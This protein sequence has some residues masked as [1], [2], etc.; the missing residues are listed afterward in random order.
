MK[1]AVIGSSNIDLTLHVDHFPQPGETISSLSF[2]QANGGKGANQAVACARLGGEVTFITALG[3]DTYAPALLS[4]F[5]A[6]GIDTSKI[7][8]RTGVN[9][10]LAFILIDS[11]GENNITVAAGA[12]ATLSPEDIEN[13]RSVIENA[14]V[15]VMQAEIPYQSVKAAATIAHAAGTKVLYN[16]APVLAVDDDMMSMTD[17]LVVNENEASTLAGIQFTG[18]NCHAIADTLHSRGAST[19]VITLGAKGAYAYD[20]TAEHFIEAFRVKAVDTVGAGDTFCGAL[21]V[22]CGKD[23][24]IDAAALRFASAASALSVQ[25]HGAQPSVPTL[26]A[27]NQFL[28]TQ[29]L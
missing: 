14:D 3:A 28:K 8:L 9:T 20:G 23:G 18:D 19:V 25:C 6:D 11:T 7:V 2:G 13:C 16:P 17:I 1:I 12:N 26:E 21:A 10:G 4:D 24:H 15:L 5:A 27:T 22:A 29:T